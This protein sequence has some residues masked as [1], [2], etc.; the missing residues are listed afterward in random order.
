MSPSRRQ[1][2]AGSVGRRP[3]TGSPATALTGGGGGGVVG[4]Y[5]L[6]SLPLVAAANFSSVESVNRENT[7]ETRGG[8]TFDGGR[9]QGHPWLDG[10]LVEDR[11][12]YWPPGGCRTGSPWPW[13]D[14]RPLAT[15]GGGRRSGSP[16]VGRPAGLCQGWP[17]LLGSPL[18]PT[19]FCTLSRDAS[20]TQ[21]SSRDS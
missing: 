6:S 14:G 9:G 7:G 13:T 10:R 12:A 1:V 5:F 3:G 19:T 8:A 16:L 18:G 21:G 17:L 4:C 20:H 15:T 11:V 2:A